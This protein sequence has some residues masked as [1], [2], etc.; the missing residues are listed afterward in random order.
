M[1]HLLLTTIAAVLLVGCGSSKND[2]LLIEASESGNIEDVKEYLADG[3][4]VNARDDQFGGTP[5]HGAA[6][7]GQTKIAELL[8]TEGAE[9]DSKDDKYEV[10]PLHYA[11]LRGQKEIPNYLSP[12]AQM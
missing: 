4:N 10:T 2:L 8:L 11:A 3:T 12:V 9:V 7:Y 1:K 5:L 6:G